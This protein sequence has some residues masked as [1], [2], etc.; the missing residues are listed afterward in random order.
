MRVSE[1]TTENSERLGQQARPEFEPGTSRL[2][3]LR[4]T[5]PLLE[6]PLKKGITNASTKVQ[7]SQSC[8]LMK[9][10]VNLAKYLVS[11]TN[12]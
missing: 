1:N 6:G 5:T 9:I 12:L 2:P 10:F 4:A 8:K 3:V 11:K 7:R